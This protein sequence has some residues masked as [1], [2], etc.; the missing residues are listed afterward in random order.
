MIRALAALA[1]FVA[2]IGVVACADDKPA[3]APKEA[4]NAVAPATPTP[5]T[6]A[7]A[8]TP[9]PVPTPVPTPPPPP[10]EKGSGW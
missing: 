10:A 8:T 1:L 4:A 5:P 6:E 2:V 9:P 3:E 7:A